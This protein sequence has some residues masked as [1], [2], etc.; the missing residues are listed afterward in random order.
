[1]VTTYKSVNEII[2]RLFHASHTSK[3]SWCLRSHALPT[4]FLS[5]PPSNLF[6]LFFLV[7]FFLSNMLGLSGFNIV[8]FSLYITPS[9]LLSLS[10]YWYNYIPCHAK[11]QPYSYDSLGH[12]PHIHNMFKTSSTRQHS[13]MQGMHVHSK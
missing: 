12:L 3:W 7:H 1:M 13:I 4:Y 5:F 8:P 2:G 6:S 10:K 11:C 9:Y